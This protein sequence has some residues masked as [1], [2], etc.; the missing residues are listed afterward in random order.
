MCSAGKHGP[1]TNPSPVCLFSDSFAVCLHQ[2]VFFPSIPATY[3][4]YAGPCGHPPDGQQLSS[5]T[6]LLIC[7]G[8]QGSTYA[9]L[10]S[11]WV[12]FCSFIF[13]FS[14]CLAKYLLHV[15]Y[16]LRKGVSCSC[17][18]RTHAFPGELGLVDLLGLISLYPPRAGG[19]GCPRSPTAVLRPCSVQLLDPCNC[20]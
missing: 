6:A 13:F 8:S 18:G 20:E 1:E 19:L 9:V 2:P 11:Q 5:A 17:C 16:D 14:C 15:R 3:F 12:Y 10:L 7:A 4:V